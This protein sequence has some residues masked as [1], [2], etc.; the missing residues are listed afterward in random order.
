MSKN[1]IPQTLLWIL[2]I[3]LVVAAG[4]GLYFWERGFERDT[5]F[6]NAFGFPAHADFHE[7]ELMK[8]YNTL[9]AEKQ[10]VEK[11]EGDLEQVRECPTCLVVGSSEDLTRSLLHARERLAHD[12]QVAADEGYQVSN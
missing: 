10:E 9:G 3:G 6:K 11:L 1:R 12:K 7:I 2:I 8:L 4:A 5:E